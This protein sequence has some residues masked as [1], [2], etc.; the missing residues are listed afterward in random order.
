M[1]CGGLGLARLGLGLFHLRQRGFGGGGPLAQAGEVDDVQRN[2][3]ELDAN[4]KPLDPHGLPAQGQHS[5]NQGHSA[6]IC[7]QPCED[8]PG[9]LFER[10]QRLKEQ[11]DH[12][13]ASFRHRA[14]SRL[15]RFTSPATTRPPALLN[16]VSE[17]QLAAIW[18]ALIW[19]RMVDRQY[20]GQP[21]L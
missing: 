16:Q 17:V 10:G 3:A 11:R 18:P 20:V 5:G 9:P 6:G 19:R 13:A 1:I 8:L 14:F 4:M 15:R 12:A 21:T 2:R 7:G